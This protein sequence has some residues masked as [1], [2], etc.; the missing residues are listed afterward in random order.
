MSYGTGKLFY[1]VATICLLAAI[2]GEIHAEESLPMCNQDHR[3]P[4]DAFEQG[5]ELLADCAYDEAEKCFYKAVARDRENAIYRSQLAVAQHVLGKRLEAHEN[6]E[7]ALNM[8]GSNPLEEEDRARAERLQRQL[9]ANYLVSVTVHCDQPEVRITL[10]KKVLSERDKPHWVLPGGYEF[11]ATKPGYMPFTE[12]FILS[13]G[14]H[15]HISLERLVT[16]NETRPLTQNQWLLWSFVGTAAVVGLLGVLPS[17]EAHENFE[18]YDRQVSSDCRA[19]C[20]EGQLATEA[21]NTRM[22]AERQRDLADGLFRVGGSLLVV[23]LAF[24]ILNR[25][26][27]DYYRRHQTVSIRPSVGLDS[28]AVSIHINR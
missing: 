21:I 14:H 12:R 8:R 22:R 25:P 10:G 19:G 7:L 1:R 2:S 3:T 15:R 9:E 26:S 18:S 24:A 27:P 5:N 4:H 20:Y 16:I 17:I 11:K 28:V 13:A 23:G 6:L